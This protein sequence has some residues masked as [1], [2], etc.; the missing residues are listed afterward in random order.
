MV[1]PHAE[2]GRAPTLEVRCDASPSRHQTFHRGIKHQ[3]VKFLQLRSMRGHPGAEKTAEA[4][5]EKTQL[6]LKK[7]KTPMSPWLLEKWLVSTALCS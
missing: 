7:R 6:R 4:G 1:L 5:F 3:N 2:R